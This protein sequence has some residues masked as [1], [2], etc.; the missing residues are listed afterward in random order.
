M[1]F[2]IVARFSRRRTKGRCP[3]ESAAFATVVAIGGRQILASVFCLIIG[4]KTARAVAQGSEDYA[5]RN[6]KERSTG[7]ERC[8]CV[9]A[10]LSDG[11]SA[12]FREIPSAP[13]RNTFGPDPDAHTMARPDP[14]P[15]R[16]GSHG[17]GRLGQRRRR[18]DVSLQRQ[19]VLGA[20]RASVRR[21]VVR[22]CRI[23]DQATVFR[24]LRYANMKRQ[25]RFI[26]I[27]CGASLVMRHWR[28]HMEI[29]KGQRS[30]CDQ[31]KRDQRERLRAEY[32]RRPM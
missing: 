5:H 31:A 16:P 17:S 29:Y 22:G 15:A 26:C 1:I 6:R 2:V 7:Y 20:S 14:R 25:P 30:N 24:V 12:Y 9:S 8:Y 4:K 10:R 11:A 13:Y 19:P 21:C 23:L 18:L 3:A 32:D 28:R 27:Y